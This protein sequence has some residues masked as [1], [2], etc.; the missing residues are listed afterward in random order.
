MKKTVSKKPNRKLSKKV[1]PKSIKSEK[2]SDIRNETPKITIDEASRPIA[3]PLTEFEKL[4]E[5]RRL[6]ES[7]QNSL[8]K[9]IKGSKEEVIAVNKRIDHLATDFNSLGEKLFKVNKEIEEFFV[10]EANG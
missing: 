9:Y 3:I 10:K 7:D 8:S 4:Q 1:K 2:L 5:K 6:L